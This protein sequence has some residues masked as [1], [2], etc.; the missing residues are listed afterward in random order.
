[1]LLLEEEGGD[2][3]ELLEKKGGDMLDQEHGGPREKNTCAGMTGSRAAF[4]I[5]VGCGGVVPGR[6]RGEAP[7]MEELP[8]LGG[9][10]LAWVQLLDV[11]VTTPPSPSIAPRG[12]DEQS[13]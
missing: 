10:G 6:Q 5:G 13:G 3:L 12:Q 2:S 9:G 1:V 4:V 11:A 8:A 7:N